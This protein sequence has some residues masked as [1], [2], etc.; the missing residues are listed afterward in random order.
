M[1]S[2]G[3]VLHV[4]RRAPTPAPAGGQSPELRVSFHSFTS[5]YQSGALASVSELRLRFTCQTTPG[6]EPALRTPHDCCAAV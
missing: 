4:P 2:H 1:L 3:S 6:Q 5:E